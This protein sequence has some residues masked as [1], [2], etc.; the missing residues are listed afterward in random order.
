VELASDITICLGESVQLNFTEDE[1]TT[2]TWTSTDPLFSDF[3][4]PQPGV[5]PTET[6]T[7]SLTA[8]NGVCDDFVGS[9][10]VEVIGNI[11]LDILPDDFFLCPGSSTNI[12]ADAIGGSSEETF[13]WTGS[14]GSSFTGSSIT[15][16]PED[17]TVYTLVY[18]SGGGC[19]TITDSVL[20][21]VGDGV[22]PTGA[23]IIQDMP[24]NLFEG[25]SI[26]LGVNYG[27]P[28]DASELNFTWT[29]L[30]EDSTEVTPLASGLGLDTIQT[31]IF[32][33]GLHEFQVEITTPDDCSYFA[34]VTGDFEEIIVAVPNTFTPNGDGA[35]DVF[36]IVAQANIEDMEVLE[37][38][39]YNRWG[40]LVYDNDRPDVG[41]DGNANGKEQPTEVYFYL[42]R[43]ARPNGFELGVF[44]GDVTLI[45]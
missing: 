4:N 35:N 33:P 44:Q 20:I 26:L 28:F 14:D 16:M 34:S 13:T 18:E 41:W 10:T 37:F 27:S 38:K 23:E 24:G 2:Y 21:E 7:Y 45:R 42:I 8:S 40:Q 3:N 29:V 31:Q 11:M 19:T 39:V 25:D 9:V 30:Y 17:S 32:P 15:V 36:N 43:I 6:A 12:N 1:N 22:F 5:S